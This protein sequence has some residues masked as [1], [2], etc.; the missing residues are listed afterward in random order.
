MRKQKESAPRT[1]RSWRARTEQGRQ[2]PSFCEFNT[3]RNLLGTP[4]SS[5]QRFSRRTHW[6]K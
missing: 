4:A 3:L 5:D 6:R 1:W 2:K